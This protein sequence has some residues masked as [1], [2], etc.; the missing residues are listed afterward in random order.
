MV[1]RLLS[2]LMVVYYCDGVEVVLLSVFVFGN[3]SRMICF[4]V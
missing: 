2:V 4:G 1:F 3:H